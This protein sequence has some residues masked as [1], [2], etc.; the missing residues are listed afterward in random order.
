MNAADRQYAGLITRILAFSI[1]AA[2]VVAVASLTG[3]VAGLVLSVLHASDTAVTGAAVL[4]G[5]LYVVWSASYFMTFWATTGQTPGSR[6]MGV[7]VVA[8]EG[9]GRLRPRRALLRFAALLLAA[10]PFCAG[11]LLILVDDRR[12]GLHDVLAGT[13]VLYVPAPVRRVAPPSPRA[14]ASSRG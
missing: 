3:V 10:V 12:R 1:D 5:F 13:L 11:F 4:G 8:T 7:R 2:I 6:L 14:S 9:D